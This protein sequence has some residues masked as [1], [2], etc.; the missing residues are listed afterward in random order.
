MKKII[1]IIIVAFTTL[2]CSSP[3]KN[4]VVKILN[5]K[6]VTMN[7]EISETTIL[8]YKTLN[9]KILPN[10]ASSKKVII[11]LVI[12]DNDV[13]E[14]K[15]RDLLTTIYRNKSNEIGVPIT[16]GIYAYLSKDKANSGMAQWIGMLSKSYT[17]SIPKISINESQLKY[18]NSKP[19]TK[20]GL[21]ENVRK[22]IWNLIIK[23]EDKAQKLADIKYPL[24]DSKT[25]R[26]NSQKNL[27]LNRKLVKQYKNELSKQLKIKEQIIDSI[28]SEG[29]EY[30]WTFPK[31]Y[32]ND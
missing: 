9:K 15:V 22:E 24:D 6:P 1:L 8:N 32:Y 11:N 18:A 27:Q 16:I 20:F 25:V 29:L 10:T 23:Y 13:T 31:Y 21:N 28:S 5:E 30:G 26:S 7:K 17:Q 19:E 2:Y 4:E 12:S 14:S 3:K